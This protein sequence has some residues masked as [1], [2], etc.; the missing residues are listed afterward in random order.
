MFDGYHCRSHPL[1]SLLVSHLRSRKL[2]DKGDMST[3]TDYWHYV[4]LIVNLGIER[5]FRGYCFDRS[6]RRKNSIY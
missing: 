5:A 6:Q 3:G 2:L 1:T 4:P